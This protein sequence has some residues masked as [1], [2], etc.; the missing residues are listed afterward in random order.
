MTGIALLALVLGGAVAGARPPETERVIEVTARKFA[1]TPSEIA[2]QR[3]VPVVLELTSLDREHGF[4]LP[5]FGVDT[6]IEPGR[7]TRVR[8]VPTQAGHFAF[9]CDVFCGSGHDDMAG[10]LVVTE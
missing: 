6:R 5:A 4:K 9:A 7:I 2:V 10:E 1:Y 3:G 8:I